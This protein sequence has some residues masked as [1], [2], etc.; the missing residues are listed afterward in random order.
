ML[1]ISNLLIVLQIHGY[2]YMFLLMFIEGT[3]VTYTAAFAAAT[4]VFHISIV[5]L[6]SVLGFTT[7]DLLFFFI[8][9]KGKNILIDNFIKNIIGKERTRKI[10]KYLK[11]N[12]GKTIAAIK[13]TPI[14]PIPGLMLCGASGLKTKTFLFNSFLTSF[15]YST[16][17]TVLGYYSGRAFFSL[18]KGVKYIELIIAGAVILVVIVLLLLNYLSKKVSRGIEKF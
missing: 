13:L 7:A 15:I 3:A 14:I 12:P 6:I 2:V 17:I 8:G 16:I 4:G 5:Y 10:Q 1:D 11:E 9:K 18:A